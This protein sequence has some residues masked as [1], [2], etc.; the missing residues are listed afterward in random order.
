[1]VAHCNDIVQQCQRNIKAIIQNVYVKIERN[2]LGG[3]T[4]RNA[5]AIPSD[6]NTPYKGNVHGDWLKQI[7]PDGTCFEVGKRT[8]HVAAST[9]IPQVGDSILYSRS[10][11]SAFV[12]GH[13]DSL[14]DVQCNVPQFQKIESK[15]KKISTAEENTYGECATL[16][17]NKRSSEENGED[18]FFEKTSSHWMKG[19]VV[20]VRS[21]FPRNM[22][23]KIKDSFTIVTPIL[24][25][26][27]RLQYSRCDGTM[28][29]CWRPCLFSK[30]DTSK[31]K[32][33]NN[34]KYSFLKPAWISSTDEMQILPP[35]SPQGH[36]F[37]SGLPKDTTISIEKCFDFLKHRC[38]NG[39]NQDA[40]AVNPDSALENAERGVTINLNSQSLPS[41]IDFFSP[42]DAKYVSR[43]IKKAEC[44]DTLK[45]LS[46]VGYMPLWSLEAQHPTLTGKNKTIRHDSRMPFPSLCLELIRLRITSGYYR[47]KKSVV[48]DISES[49]VASVLY[50]LSEPSTRK[51]DRV[52]IRKI[53]KF[54]L[55]GKGNGKM[56]KIPIKKISKKKKNK[57]EEVAA[58]APAPAPAPTDK[59]TTKKGSQESLFDGLSDEE[60]AL[61]RQIFQIRKYHAAAIVFALNANQMEKLF[62]LKSMV[63]SP[64]QA[65]EPIPDISAIDNANFTQ[66]QLAGIQDIRN[67]LNAIGRDLCRNR[68]KFSYRNTYKLKIKCEGQIITENGSLFETNEGGSF[69]YEPAGTIA[70]LPNGSHVNL[71]IRF[72]NEYIHAEKRRISVESESLTNELNHTGISN[73]SQPIVTA[74]SISSYPSSMIGQDHFIFSWPELKNNEEL[75]RT[76]FCSKGRMNA[77]VMCQA[78]GISLLDCRVRKCH[79]NPDYAFNERFKGTNGYYSLLLPWTQTQDNHESAANAPSNVTATAS[80][81]HLVTDTTSEIQRVKKEAAVAFA[82]QASE[83]KESFIKADKGKLIIY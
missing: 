61:T 1:L 82:K 15:E 45:N 7:A 53:A 21:S 31:C 57:N 67:L 23:N 11:H 13:R 10:N 9:W 34:T 27:L 74:R 63:E 22:T 30:L 25:V 48:N 36:E 54:C 50:L 44:K 49:Y 29:V 26:E 17:E 20:S 12:Y 66:E 70:L 77:C 16:H 43:G 37:T 46:S 59:K 73:V 32:T 35:D 6:L 68:F 14:A 28:F 83:V 60:K 33:C 79:S 80:N 47:N 51:N 76:L 69:L 72:G 8:R 64:T 56:S 39:M 78:T 75:V 38:I 58:P 4:K 2:D 19:T 40:F 3:S 41:Y 55:S 62:C 5:I 81:Q 65:P 42:L 24:I 18:D 52:S 71:Q